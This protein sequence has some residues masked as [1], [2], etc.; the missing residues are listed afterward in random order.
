MAP[1]AIPAGVIDRIVEVLEPEE[2][3]LFG[4]R[5]GIPDRG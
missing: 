2:V 3:W 4:S 1:A 5:A